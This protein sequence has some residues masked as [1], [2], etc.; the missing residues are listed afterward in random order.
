[1]TAPQGSATI[2]CN[3]WLTEGTPMPDNTVAYVAIYSDLDSAMTI[4]TCCGS[5]LM[6]M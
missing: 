1:M 4:S 6:T 2:E 3:G 5:C